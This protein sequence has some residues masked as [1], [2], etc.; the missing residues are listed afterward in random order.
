MAERIPVK[1]FM[2]GGIW[3][4]EYELSLTQPYIFPCW[5]L[6]GDGIKR[7]TETDEQYQE[8]CERHGEP[9]KYVFMKTVASKK[10][11]LVPE[12]MDQYWA[13]EEAKNKTMEMLAAWESSQAP[14]RTRK[15]TA[16]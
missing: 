11:D 1:K 16:K 9:K 8:F 12:L 6:Y 13:V 5:E 3:C 4:Y 10:E 15:R 14:K 7:M 2:N